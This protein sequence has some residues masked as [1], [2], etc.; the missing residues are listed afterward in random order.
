MSRGLKRDNTRRR[1]R[2]TLLGDDEVRAGRL[3]DN[4]G[5]PRISL[6]WRRGLEGNGL[7]DERGNLV[8]S[9]RSVARLF[10]RTWR[11]G[12]AIG[13][14]CLCLVRLSLGRLSLGWVS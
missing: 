8:L 12:C 7:S 3:R 1:T 2:R 9:W 6:L 4:L 14:V 10:L 11:I 5:V 13:L